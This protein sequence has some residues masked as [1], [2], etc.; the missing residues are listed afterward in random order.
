VFSDSGS[1]GAVVCNLART[2]EPHE[3]SVNAVFI[4]QE[5]F[6]GIANIRLARKR[7][8]ARDKKPRLG[9]GLKFHLPEGKPVACTPS[10]TYDARFRRSR[11]Q[12]LW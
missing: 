9:R 7:D 12:V 10:R 5:L 1:K 8:R 6:F 2:R 4:G 11:P 3:F